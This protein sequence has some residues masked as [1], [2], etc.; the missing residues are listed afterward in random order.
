MG[1]ATAQGVCCLMLYKG[2]MAYRGGGGPHQIGENAQCPSLARPQKRTC[3][4]EYL[5]VGGMLWSVH[6]GASPN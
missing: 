5:S 6:V 3:N 2:N 1:K 4:S